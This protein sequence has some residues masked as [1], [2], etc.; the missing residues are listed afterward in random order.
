MSHSTVKTPVG[1]GTDTDSE[2]SRAA[3]SSGYWLWVGGLL[4]L[5][6]TSQKP[7]NPK[8]LAMPACSRQPCCILKQAL[9]PNIFQCGE[10]LHRAQDPVKGHHERGDGGRAARGGE[11]FKICAWCLSGAAACTRQQE[12]CVWTICKLLA[13]QRRKPAVR[14]K[15]LCLLSE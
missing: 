12:W 13:V 7:G 3:G 4:S 9:A 1:D 2:W 6:P 14:I 8:C 15:C 11:R 5:V 10:G